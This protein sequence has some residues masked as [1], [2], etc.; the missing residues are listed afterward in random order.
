MKKLKRYELIE[1]CDTGYININVVRQI[2]KG[3]G[4]FLDEGYLLERFKDAKRA[5][6]YELR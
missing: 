6:I 5:Y 1:N 2:Y 4:V 3:E